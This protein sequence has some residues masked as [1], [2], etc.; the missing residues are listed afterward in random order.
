MEGS[1]RSGEKGLCLAY[2]SSL[3]QPPCTYEPINDDLVILIRALVYWQL[4]IVSHSSPS[5]LF[6]D[7]V[8]AHLVGSIDSHSVPSNESHAG[9]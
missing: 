6:H 2:S 4:S 8:F 7:V 9:L 5:L 1:T 3:L